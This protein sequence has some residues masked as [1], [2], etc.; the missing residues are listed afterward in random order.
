MHQ[1]DNPGP[2]GPEPAIS[3]RPLVVLYL[4]VH[5]RAEEFV[6]P[7]A[8]S[9]GTTRVAS[10]YLECALA[11]VA[12][13]RLRDADCY[14]ALVINDTSRETLGR[15][16]G[17]LIECIE[18]RAV[19]VITAPYAHRLEHASPHYVASRYVL[20]AI[21][22]AT[23][24]EHAD[25]PLWL[26]DLDCIWVAPE[27][28]F[29]AVPSAS[30]VGCVFIGYPPDWDTVKL[31]GDGTRRRVGELAGELGSAGRGDEVPPWVGGE[32][33]AG[34]AAALRRLAAE[35]ELLDTR[36]SQ[37]GVALATEE[38]LLSLLG[39]MGIVRFSDL[40][41]VAR[42]IQ[43]GRRHE[44]TA[45]EQPLSLGLWHLPSEKGLSLRRAADRMLRGQADRLRADL[46]DPAR[47][48]AMFNVQGTGLPRRVRDDA[49]I[50]AQK[51]AMLR[52]R[53]AGRA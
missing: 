52:A 31:G 37:R 22:A 40:S 6:Y 36:C 33:L 16:G 8:R 26:T 47:A 23:R 20:D 38:E 13:L 29:A 19:D 5:E 32:L 14:I 18:R 3:V 48:G 28:V 53:L 25:R 42:R 21:V 7:S 24:G 27:K 4:Y 9:T 30:E 12:S 35:A 39:A 43:T 17:E 10:R 45:V 2:I 11:Q 44:A 15:R 50:I 34:S 41:F 1:Q 46:E 49:W 51:L